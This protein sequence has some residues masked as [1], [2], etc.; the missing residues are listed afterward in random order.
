MK[1][2]LNPYDPRDPE[3]R[4]LREE[5]ATT[6]AVLQRTAIDMMR[7]ADVRSADARAIADRLLNDDPLWGSIR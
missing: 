2:V 3:V 5:R 7:A 4:D 6:R 1:R